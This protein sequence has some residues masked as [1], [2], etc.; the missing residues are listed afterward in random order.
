MKMLALGHAPLLMMAF[1][2]FYS[3]FVILAMRR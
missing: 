1:A 2:V 3:G